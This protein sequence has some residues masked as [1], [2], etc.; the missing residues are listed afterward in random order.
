MIPKVA[1]ILAGVDLQAEGSYIVA[2]PSIHPNG[3][4][5]RWAPGRALGEAPL[6][7]TAS[8]TRP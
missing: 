7:A 8:R 5:Y 3:G 2:P 1:G 6:P 4:Q